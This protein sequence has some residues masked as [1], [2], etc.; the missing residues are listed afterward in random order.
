MGHA[1]PTFER[2]QL[3]LVLRRLRERSGMTQQAGAEAVGKVRSRIVQ[4]EDGT[5]TASE[6]DLRTL[7]DCYTVTGDERT[8]VLELGAQAR[9][10][11]QRRVHVDNLPDAYRRFADL[12]ASASEINVYDT[13]VIP[14]LLQS[15]GYLQALFA[16]AEGVWWAADDTQAEDR[17]AYR[18]DRQA[19]MLREGDLRI[20]R[21]VVTEDALRANMGA[22]EIMREQ[23]NHLLGLLDKLPDLNI[24]VLRADAYGNPLRGYGM[25]I[26]GF[27][28]RGASIG[29]SSP[30][31]GPSTYYDG[32]PE[33]TA[34]IR[35]FYRVWEAALSREESRRLIQHIAKE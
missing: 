17:W 29:Y 23:L 18:M 35:A 26:L 11:Q 19:T 30:V 22:P 34:M 4:L 16:E 3:G 33:T 12:E 25:T 28:E 31:L 13:G 24:R 27:G 2:R 5:A 10:R 9:R 7:L 6:E 32:E 1:R 21:F 14:G 15:T 8:T 20:M